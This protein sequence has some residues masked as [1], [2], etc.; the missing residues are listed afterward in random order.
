MSQTDNQAPKSADLVREVRVMATA[1]LGCSSECRSLATAA[2]KMAA[3][4][5]ME[6][7]IHDIIKKMEAMA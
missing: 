7:S 3:T 4:M 6:N 5:R 1:V 2:L